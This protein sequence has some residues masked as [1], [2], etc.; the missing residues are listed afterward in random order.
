MRLENMRAQP[1]TVRIQ[2]G[3][4]KSRFSCQLSVCE[5]MRQGMGGW[6]GGV[7]RVA[8]LYGRV[9][10][11]SARLSSNKLISSLCPAW[12][13]NLAAID[14]LPCTIFCI[15]NYS[16]SEFSTVLRSCPVGKRAWFL[17]ASLLK[18]LRGLAFHDALPKS[19][20]RPCFQARHF[21][22]FHGS[23][24]RLGKAAPGATRLQ[25]LAGL[26]WWSHAG[27]QKHRCKANRWGKNRNRD[28]VG[29]CFPRERKNRILFTLNSFYLD[30][31]KLLIAIR[32]IS[33]CL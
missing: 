11:T 9:V 28:M 24:A 33:E 12:T 32:Q 3:G 14:L 31:A 26:L 10:E 22:M 25:W 27:Y 21:R 20:P 15:Q 4:D 30:L 8:G 2:T 23:V 29:I 5:R 17:S 16:P 1:G 19:P 7:T 18:K 6:A 13:E